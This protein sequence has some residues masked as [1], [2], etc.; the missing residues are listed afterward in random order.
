M[1]SPD[2]TC[3]QRALR[4]SLR[5]AQLMVLPLEMPGLERRTS[6]TARRGAQLSL[7]ARTLLKE[8]STPLGLVS[9]AQ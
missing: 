1:A 4:H 5:S 7:G 3:Y 8:S 9:K 2:V 6:V